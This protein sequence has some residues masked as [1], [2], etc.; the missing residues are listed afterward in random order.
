M[1]GKEIKNKN[2]SDADEGSAEMEVKSVIGLY[3][4]NTALKLKYQTVLITI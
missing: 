2:V 1:Q 4:N 3:S